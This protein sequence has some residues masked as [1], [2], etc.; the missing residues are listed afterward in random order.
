MAHEGFQ[1]GF[2]EGCARG[3]LGVDVLLHTQ[4]KHLGGGA[5]ACVLR[6]ACCVLHAACCVRAAP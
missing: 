5:D 6:A 3:V 1:E 2:Q 4:Y